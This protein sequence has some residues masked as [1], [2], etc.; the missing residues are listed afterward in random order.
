MLFSGLQ[1]GLREIGRLENKTILV[2]YRYADGHLDRVSEFIAD[3]RT[4]NT[5]VLTL[6][7]NG[8]QTDDRMAEAA[9][10]GAPWNV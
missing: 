5:D 7:V 6:P 2:Q 3:L 10:Q 9:I 4:L 1:Q 8:L